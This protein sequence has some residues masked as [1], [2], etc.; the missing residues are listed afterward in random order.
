MFQCKTEL[1]EI[2][3]KVIKFTNNLQGIK[4]GKERNFKEID[5]SNFKLILNKIQISYWFKMILKIHRISDDQ[6]I[7]FIFYNI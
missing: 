4:K 2:F 6:N 1:W 7:Y 3:K 5:I